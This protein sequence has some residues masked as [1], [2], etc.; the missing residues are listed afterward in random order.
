MDQ[1]FFKPGDTVISQGEN[2]NDLYVVEEGSL[3]CSKIF[4]GETTEK[5]LRDYN[6]G[7]AF[8][9]L[10][11]LYNAPRAATIRAVTDSHLWALDRGTF[12]QIVQGASTEKR[13]KYEE[14]LSNVPLLEKMDGL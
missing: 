11:L 14:F 4:D 2:G 13:E 10:A 1:Q 8:G 3:A 5:Y 12:N 9:E 7:D 6:P